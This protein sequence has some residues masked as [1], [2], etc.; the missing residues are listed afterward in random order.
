MLDLE[1]YDEMPK[2]LPV[3]RLQ[4]VQWQT[5]CMVGSLLTVIEA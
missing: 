4:F 1:K 5:P 2:A 3:R